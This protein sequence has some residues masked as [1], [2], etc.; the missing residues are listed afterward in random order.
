LPI[1]GNPKK[2]DMQTKK[3]HFF[4]IFFLKMYFLAF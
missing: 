4:D 1:I 3:N 2:N